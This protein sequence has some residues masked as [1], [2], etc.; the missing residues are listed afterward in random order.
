MAQSY[1]KGGPIFSG[2]N[3]SAYIVIKINAAAQNAEV[4]WKEG[5]YYY[6]ELSNEKIQGYVPSNFVNAVSVPSYNPTNTTRYVAEEGAAY[7]GDN[8]TFLRATAPEYGQAVRYL[9]KKVGSLAF[10]EYPVS[11]TPKRRAWFPHMSLA[12]GRIYAYGKYVTGQVINSSG[13]NWC[14]TRPWG[15][16]G[17]LAIDV[18]RRYSNNTFYGNSSAR[19]K[20]IYAIA[21]GKVVVSTDNI[22]SDSE[23]VENGVHYGGNGKC[24]VIEHITAKGKK[25]YST[26]SL[27]NLR[28]VNV[29]STVSKHQVIGTMGS[30]GNV[31]VV[32]GDRTVHLHLHI[33]NYNAGEGAEGYKDGFT[34][35]SDH[36]EIYSAKLGKNVRYYNPTRYF[37]DGESFIDDN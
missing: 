26:Y 6:I 30:T 13:D 27:L 25:Y 11:S 19:G 10:I 20:D 33:T 15:K 35:S 14:V 8:T 17:H 34:G 37:Q 9:G 21:D 16:S 2:P 28:S 22:K 5:Q 7:W 23:H 32:N 31:Q 29:G 12:V 3:S 4:L 18:R 36:T 24:V 1:F